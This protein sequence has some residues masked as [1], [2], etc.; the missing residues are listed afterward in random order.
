MA[1]LFCVTIEVSASASETGKNQNHT[2][3]L[4]DV[5]Y[6]QMIIREYL[7]P[8]MLIAI[9]ALVARG[10]SSRGLDIVGNGVNYRHRDENSK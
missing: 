10:A 3:A 9:A 7:L 1:C 4:K 5:D 2:I 6:K 8:V